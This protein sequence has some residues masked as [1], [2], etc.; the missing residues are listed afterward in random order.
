MTERYGLVNRCRSVRITDLGRNRD[1][2]F[3]GHG[4]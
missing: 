4:I 1:G 3:R 2:R